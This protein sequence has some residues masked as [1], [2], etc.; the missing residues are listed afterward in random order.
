MSAPVSD[1]LAHRDRALPLAHSDADDEAELA[2]Y[3]RAAAWTPNTRRAYARAWD[4][5]DAWAARAGVP[6]IPARAKDV[7]A[8]LLERAAAGRSIATLRAAAAGIAAMY[9]AAGHPNPCPPHG[10]V[11]A[12]LT[13]L[14]KE[15]KRPQRQVAGL[16]AEALIAIRATARHPRGRES[17][18][19]AVARGRLDVALAGLLA[20]AGLRRSEAAAL[21]W[22][23]I[24]RAPDGSGRVTVRHSKTDQEGEGAVVA[25]TRRTMDDLA[26]IRDGAPAEALVIGLSAD[27][28]ARRIKATAI[29]ADLGEEFSGH[30]GRVG[31]ARR[32]TQAGAPAAAVQRQGRWKSP[33][34]VARYTRAESAGEALRYLDQ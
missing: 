29:A 1:A 17:T 34:M 30:S 21:T 18:V 8:Y 5:W 13:R 27:R 19:A 28:I 16:T 32:M 15:L 26:A 14:A 4:A 23:D 6:M 25:I 24:E 9:T 2:A 11:S 31:M 3:E 22:A 12:T 10:S 33:A 20:D 7:R